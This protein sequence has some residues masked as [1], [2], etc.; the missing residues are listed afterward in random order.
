MRKLAIVALLCLSLAILALPLFAASTS[1]GIWQ[2]KGN[3]IANSL[4]GTSAV[5]ANPSVVYRASGCL[6]IASP[7]YG[8]WAFNQFG[9]AA[10]KGIDYFESADGLTNWSAYAS[11]PMI[12]DNGT[13]NTFFPTVYLESGTFYIFAGDGQSINEWTSANGVTALT[14]IGSIITPGAGGTWDH[15]GVFQLNIIDTITGTTT[16]Y[17]SGN[18]GVGTYQ[19]GCVTT[20]NLTTWT[21][22]VG[23]PIFAGLGG[24]PVGAVTFYKSGGTYY[25]YTNTYPQNAQLKTKGFSGFVRFSSS[26]VTGPWT[27]LTYPSSGNPVFTYY[28]NTPFDFSCG[29]GASAQVGDPEL[30]FPPDGSMHLYYDSGCDFGIQVGISAAVIP[31]TTLS[32]LVASNEGVFNVPVSGF[33]QLNLLTLASDPG[34]GP[35]ANPIGGN[36]SPLAVS[37]AFGTAQRI[38]NTFESSSTGAP[39]SD[40]YWNAITWGADQWSQSTVCVNNGVFVG[41]DSRMSTTGAITAYRMYWNGTLGNSGTLA[42][43]REVAGTATT[44]FSNTGLTVNVGDTIMNVTIGNV[45]YY[46]WNGYLIGSVSDSTN[47][48]GAVGFQM[49]SGA[50]SVA[51][52][53][54]CAWS[55]GTFQSTSASIGGKAGVGGKAGIGK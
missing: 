20:T 14:S 19:L 39:N 34:T 33:P 53:A 45:I 7:C 29:V 28:A 10:I 36:W 44:L 31:H 26:S 35:N 52:A 42:I 9:L 12:L 50:G 48:T 21:K 2:P 18:D 22:C 41:A 23:N 55:G 47:T 38:S 51:N 49:A 5:L 24:T 15:D 11:N 40:S 43:Q 1:F 27:M 6:V 8:M 37:G 17:Y 54:I 3:I 13:G 32:Q 4:G 46:Y 25:A 16:A 30:V